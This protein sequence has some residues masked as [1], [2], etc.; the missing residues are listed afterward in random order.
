[1]EKQI[2]GRGLLAG[3][4]AGLLA[5]VWAKV[6]IEPIIDRAIE[7]EDGTAEAHEMLEHAAGGHSH[8]E[9]GGELFTRAVQ[10]GLG[11]GVGIVLFA[12]AMA[13]LAAVVFCV[14]Y[15]R[16][17]L[18]ARSL[19]VLVSAGMLVSLWIVPGLKYP[20]NPPATSIDET[21]RE[22]AFLYLL[23]VVISGALLVAAIVFGHKIAEKSGAW[24]GVLAGAGAYIVTVGIAILALPTID[25][26]PGPI[27]DDSGTIIFEGF[28]AEEL[29]DFRVYVL[30]TQL[31]MWVT[32]AVVF[33]AL[34]HKLLDSREKQ[35]LD[36]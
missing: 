1:M 36:A 20:P 25:E 33:S 16:T 32:I 26:V 21:I 8:G 30:G 7:F 15:A 18:S 11:L 35:A 24:N 5:F 28:P 14:L 12:M 29:W 6:M 17:A 4:V 2:I 31:I 3:L 13:A 27:T 19:A 23:M 10:S 22:R 34:V 9:E